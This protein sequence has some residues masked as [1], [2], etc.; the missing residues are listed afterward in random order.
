MSNNS[1][2]SKT[3]KE[4]ILKDL[5]S[6]QQP[7]GERKNISLN[8]KLTIAK[9][10]NVNMKTI[11]YILG[12]HRCDP[13]KKSSVLPK[14]EIKIRE[15]LADVVKEYPCTKKKYIC[16][17]DKKIIAEKYD[18]S[19]NVVERI[20]R[21]IQLDQEDYVKRTSDFIQSRNGT[22]IEA[23]TRLNCIHPRSSSLKKGT[24][25]KLANK[26]EVNVQTIQRIWKKWKQ[27]NSYIVQSIKQKNE[28]VS[29]STTKSTPTKPQKKDLS[30]QHNVMRKKGNK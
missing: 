6:A 16:Q 13:S 20:R 27:N 8:D 2:S 4:S 29:N 24:L 21:T 5:L 22:I 3:C 30:H 28:K 12:V 19:T 9:K 1:P 25:E 18:V 26:F 10:Y 14:D 17:D 11:E 23:I 7:N 15:E